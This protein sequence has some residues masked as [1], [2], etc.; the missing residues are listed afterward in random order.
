MGNGVDRFEDLDVWKL[1][2][3]LR[4]EVLEFTNKGPAAKDF[5]YRDQIR[6]ATS[7]A[8]RNTAEGFGRF[9]PG[10]FAR[11]LGFAHASLNEVQ[12]QLLD[13]RERGYIDQA[14][15]DRLW[16]LSKRALGANTSLMMYLKDCAAKR[17]KPWL[18]GG[19][20]L[21]AR[22]RTTLGGSGNLTPESPEPE[23]SK[24][25]EPGTDEPENLEH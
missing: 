15:F 2:D 12:D 20:D 8:A 17:R 22:E 10:E 1:A 24:A 14:L 9:N 19:N 7:S 23:N 25:V 21:P 11:F 5:K 18:R 3:E 6:D 13:G 16:I 4:R